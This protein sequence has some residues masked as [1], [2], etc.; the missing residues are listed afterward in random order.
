[1]IMACLDVEG[2]LL[3]EIWIAISKKTGI[4]ELRLTTRDIPDYDALMKR[5]LAIL[6]KNKITLRDIQNVIA[7]MKPLPGARKFL[8][9]LRRKAQA[10]L[11]SDTYYEFSMPLMAKLGAPTLFCN[12]LKVNRAGYLCDYVLRQRNGKEKSV[13]ALKR[14]NFTVRAVGDSYNDIAMLRAADEGFLF[15]PPPNIVKEFPELH[16]AKSYRELL[17]FLTN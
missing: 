2:V 9:D 16:V 1:M 10:I 13:R 14:L 8:D 7:T 4:P 6:K 17:K 15:N 5:R 12:T 11:L 3:P